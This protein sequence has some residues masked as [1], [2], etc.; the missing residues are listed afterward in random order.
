MDSDGGEMW[1]GVL[2]YI[3]R[4]ADKHGPYISVLTFPSM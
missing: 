2:V 3:S 4:V 1:C